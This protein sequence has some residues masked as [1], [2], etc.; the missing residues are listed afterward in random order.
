VVAPSIGEAEN[1]VTLKATVKTAD[2]QI[3]GGAPVLFAIERTTGGG[4][5]VSP[6]IVYTDNLGVATSTFTS[7]ALG[8]DSAGRFNLCHH[9]RL[10]S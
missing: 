7:G 9:N 4:E 2:D 6:V 8:S 3:V 5:T 10:F 1:N